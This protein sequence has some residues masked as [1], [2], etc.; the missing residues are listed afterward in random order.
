MRFLGSG[1]FPLCPS[2]LDEQSF[3]SDPIYGGAFVYLDQNSQP[4][5]QV[6][7]TF[8]QG[9]RSYSVACLPSDFIP[10]A[11]VILRTNY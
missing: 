10:Q 2:T 6:G 1:D 11:Y 4:K 3:P 7:S 5:A 9:H 8:Q